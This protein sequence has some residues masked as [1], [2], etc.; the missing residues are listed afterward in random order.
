MVDTTFFLA[1]T[2]SIEQAQDSTTPPVE[3]W[4]DRTKELRREL[5]WKVVSLSRY[6]DDL[7][8]S[9]YATYAD[10]LASALR[11]SDLGMKNDLS[12]LRGTVKKFVQ[13]LTE[14]GFADKAALVQKAF[15]ECPAAK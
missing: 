3:R 9:S 12:D 15:D 7:P 5:S 1:L 10:A 8:E 2:D 6:M 11:D 4:L 13:R 14:R